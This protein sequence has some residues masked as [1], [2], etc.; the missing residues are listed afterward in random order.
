[1]TLR[2]DRVFPRDTDMAEIWLRLDID[3]RGMALAPLLRAQ[4][5]F[6]NLR[7]A[8]APGSITIIRSPTQAANLDG[9]SEVRKIGLGSD[10]RAGLREHMRNAARL[11][12][13]I[14]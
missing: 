9:R 5:A 2:R 12:A 11:L 1:M 3:G 13:V 4:Q 10:F 14:D 8:S 6:L 7:P